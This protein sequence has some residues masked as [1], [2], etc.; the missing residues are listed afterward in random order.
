M[1]RADWNLIIIYLQKK[2]EGLDATK[3]WK[4]PT[5]MVKDIHGTL[6]HTDNHDL[7]TSL[8]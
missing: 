3:S 1:N 5:A 6:S 8:S 4:D 7:L 2:E